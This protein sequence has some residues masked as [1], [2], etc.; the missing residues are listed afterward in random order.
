[1][2]PESQAEPYDLAAEACSFDRQSMTAVDDI[3]A[4]LL[5][6]FPACAL[7]HADCMSYLGAQPA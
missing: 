7:G 1:M 4:E 5:E 6:G 3:A 2:R